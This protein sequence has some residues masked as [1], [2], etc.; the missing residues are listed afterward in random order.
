MGQP[1]GPLSLGLPL[2][3]SFHVVRNGFIQESVCK[4]NLI[5]LKVTARCS[6]SVITE[7]GNPQVPGQR[8]YPLPWPFF[9][10]EIPLLTPVRLLLRASQ[11]PPLRAPGDPDPSWMPCSEQLGSL[12][13]Y[14]S[15]PAPGSRVSHLPISLD[16]SAL[17]DLRTNP[18]INHLGDFRQV[19]LLPRALVS[20]LVKRG[21][22]SQLMS[23]EHC[24]EA[25]G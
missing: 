2:L 13:S 6:C 19:T 4:P 18:T 22:P 23:S 21:Q 24:W 8:A 12:W 10:Q 20:S 5:F 1:Q 9:I 16:T 3:D 25:L 14:T 17:L 7:P 15:L 11:I